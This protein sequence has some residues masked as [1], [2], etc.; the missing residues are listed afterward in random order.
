MRKYNEKQ[1]ITARVV[2]NG[3][4]V[5]AQVKYSDL[6]PRITTNKF[7]IINNYKL[8]LHE[9]DEV[10][11]YIVN[12]RPSVIGRGATY[13]R[14]Y[15]EKSKKRDIECGG[16]VNVMKL[17]VYEQIKKLGE[18]YGN[19]IR[20]FSLDNVQNIG[21]THKP[22][23][24]LYRHLGVYLLHKFFKHQ[25]TDEE[26]GSFY[27]LSRSAIYHGITRV[28]EENDPHVLRIVEKLEEDVVELINKTVDKLK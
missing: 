6:P 27:G 20:K 14:F 24:V 7:R 9:G 11:G 16:Y 3:G 4:Y 23:I 12:L 28:Y 21:R 13:L 26:I 1:P 8:Y 2:V 19:P 15:I 10:E 25:L 22:E 18:L 17:M 5:V